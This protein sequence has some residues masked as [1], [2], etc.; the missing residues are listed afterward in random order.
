MGELAEIGKIHESF[1]TFVLGL[2]LLC[3][4]NGK[5]RQPALAQHCRQHCA[6]IALMLRG[7][8]L[9]LA[10]IIGCRYNETGALGKLRQ[11]RQT[12]H[13]EQFPSVFQ[14]HRGQPQGIALLSAVRSQKGSRRGQYP[15]GH[16]RLL[17]QLRKPGR[18]GS[19]P[20]FSAA[21]DENAAVLCPAAKTASLRLGYSAHIKVR[22]QDHV[23]LVQ[24]RLILRKIAAVQRH[25]SGMQQP[26]IQPDI[27][28]IG[29]LLRVV[30]QDPQQQLR[31]A[32]VHVQT[33]AAAAQHRAVSPHGLH[34]KLVHLPAQGHIHLQLR[35]AARLRNGL[36]AILIEAL[37]GIRHVDINIAGEGLLLGVVQHDGQRKVM[38]R[39]RRILVAVGHLQ[40]YCI[41]PGREADR[42][43]EKQQH[44]KKTGDSA[45]LSFCLQAAS[46]PHPSSPLKNP[47]AV[48]HSAAAA[49]P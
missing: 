39:L 4:G 37:V 41:R 22:H 7:K 20:V 26:V 11:K 30:R 1:Q 21:E 3:R 42:Q 45:G 16:Q 19:C 17:Q 40:V 12:V 31:T 28:K 36:V 6:G 2:T 33:D 24:L 43:Q 5:L 27:I 47:P 44:E 49:V 9:Q 18:H 38:S 15:G 14:I 48:P 10:E 32:L 35:T 13:G 46:T 8:A 29:K 34:Q 25:R 23:Q